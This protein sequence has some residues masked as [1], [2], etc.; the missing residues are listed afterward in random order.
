M[1]REESIPR[2]LICFDTD[3]IFRCMDYY[4]DNDKTWF[5]EAYIQGPIDAP[6]LR[7]QIGNIA[8]MY[9]V[10]ESPFYPKNPD[11]SPIFPVINLQPSRYLNITECYNHY[12]DKYDQDP[13]QKWY[14]SNNGDYIEATKSEFEYIRH[15]RFIA[16]LHA[17]G[18]I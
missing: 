12:W 16:R 9:I 18:M 2:I 8:D 10:S 13:Q 15:D 6:Y 17:E 3:G 14:I 7:N 1:K 5:T 4:S 11:G